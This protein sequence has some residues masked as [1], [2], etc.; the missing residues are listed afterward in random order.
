MYLIIVDKA[1][2]MSFVCD[3]YK[4]Q[5]LMCCLMNGSFKL[6][7]RD[8]SLGKTYSCLKLYSYDFYRSTEGSDDMASISGTR[9]FPE[10]RCIK[11]NAYS[12]FTS[13]VYV[14]TAVV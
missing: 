1:V 5:F 14:Y 3:Y 10:S 6:G 4:V 8:K 13:L 2:S 12:K 11:Q 9:N 7:F